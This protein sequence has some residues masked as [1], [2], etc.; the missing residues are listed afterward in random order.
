MGGGGG[1]SKPE[2]PSD[3]GGLRRR[4]G[5]EAGWSETISGSTVRTKGTAR[6]NQSQG[7]MGGWLGS[8]PDMSLAGAAH[9]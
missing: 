8:F 4:S 9:E 6:Q 3:G 5:K 2:S 7:K 1:S